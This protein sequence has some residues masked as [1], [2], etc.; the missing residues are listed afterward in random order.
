[1]YPKVKVRDQQ[2]EDDQYAYGLGSLQSLKAFDAISISDLSSPDDSPTSV[3][4][5]PRSYISNSAKPA[6][7]VSTGATNNKIQKTS[8]EGTTKPRS[9]SVPRPRAVLSSPDND[10][11][12]GVSN[13][14]RAKLLPG[15]K[16]QNT[17]QSRH[18]QCKIIPRMAKAESPLNAREFKDSDQSK[19]IPRMAKG[20]SRPINAKEFKDSVH[21]ETGLQVKGR[22]A[23]TELNQKTHIR[24]GPGSARSK[25]L[26]NSMV[27]E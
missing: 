1:M 26:G 18:T 11:S 24:K 2:E 8:S 15:L 4:R 5:I 20:E 9:S 27:A 3:V 6:S 14:P 12:I 16:S 17:C 7:P 19:I 23:R 25:A 21:G 10:Q 13:K 22:L